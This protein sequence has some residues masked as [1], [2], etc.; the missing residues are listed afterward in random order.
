MVAYTFNS[1]TRKA[2]AG[3][4]VLGQSG[5]QTKTGLNRPAPCPLNL[6]LLGVFTLL[7]KAKC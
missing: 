7:L 1:S 2:Q 6:L 5:L 4:S 3:D